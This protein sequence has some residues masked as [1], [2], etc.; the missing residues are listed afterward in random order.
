MIHLTVPREENNLLSTLIYHNTAADRHLSMQWFTGL[1]HSGLLLG[2]Q[3]QRHYHG[4][5]MHLVI[6]ATDVWGGGLI[7]TIRKHE[8]LWSLHHDGLIGERPILVNRG[9]TTRDGL[10][11]V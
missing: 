1:A 10:G 9:E 11:L 7:K 5:T 8:N 4:I 2:L 6:K 3:V